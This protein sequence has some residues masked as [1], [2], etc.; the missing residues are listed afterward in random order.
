MVLA[1]ALG[2]AACGDSA[3]TGNS[4]AAP[5]SEPVPTAEPAPVPTPAPAPP[6]SA[7]LTHD[8]GDYVL[9]PGQEVG[10]QCVS[11]TLDNAES[12][13]VS[14]VTVSNSGAYHHSNWFVVPETTF[15]GEDGYFRCRDR[16]F[17]ELGAAV[18]G[19]VLFA[20]STQ[21]QLETQS[22]VPG[23]VIKVPPHHK[24][25]AGIHML[26]P[27]AREITTQFRMT[28]ELAHPRD[29]EVLLKPFRISYYA[30]DIP[31]NSEARYTAECDLEALAETVTGRP[32]DIKLYWVLPH[33]HYRGNYFRAELIGGERDGELLHT[34][35][36]FNAEANG[37]MFDPPVDLTG[38][39]GIRMTCGFRNPTDEEIGWGIGDQEMC[40]MLG[41]ASGDVLMDAWVDEDTH[42]DDG[43]DDGIF[44]R[45][46]N[47]EGLAVPSNAAQVPPTDAEMQRA[48]YVPESK[49]SDVDLPPVLLCIDASLGASAEA[50]VTFQSIRDTVLTPSCA[51]SACHGAESPV[52]GLDLETDPHEALLTRSVTSAQTEMPLVMP[53]DPSNSWLYRLLSQCEPTD[54]A[55]NVVASMPRNAPNLLDDAVIAKVRAWIEAGAPND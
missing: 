49:P 4:P 40:V 12:L 22:F 11:W 9:G 34:I 37:K 47:C 33:Y 51:F 13:W 7:S 41:L 20:Q 5:P 8:F 53:G 24:V 27:S 35:D 46:G 2:I 54:D 48:L 30:L 26:N 42:G 55:G 52:A 44:R 18:E 17:S 45:S 16:E 38:A 1:L 3:S 15:P 19:T 14:A 28:L 25:V 23:A 50:P 21:S 36:R 31:A 6:S 43:V 39:T 10:S 29:V 32:L